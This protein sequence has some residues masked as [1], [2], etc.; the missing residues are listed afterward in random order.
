MDEVFHVPQAQRYCN[1]RFSEWDPKITTFPGLYCLSAL[2]SGLA[3]YV[4]GFASACSPM[5]LRAVNA[6]LGAGALIVM[7]AL[8]RRRMTSDKAAAQAFVLSLYPVHFFFT[9]LYYTDVGSLFWVLLTHHLAAPTPGQALPGFWRIFAA[10]CS[11]FVSVAFRQ[12]NAVWLMFTFGTAALADLQASKRWGD[13]LEGSRLTPKM[14]WTFV[15]ALAFDSGRLLSRLGLLLMPV[16]LFVAFVIWNGSVVVGDHSH[17]KPVLHWAQLGYLVAVTASLWGVVGPDAAVSFASVKAFV[18]LFT[19]WRTGLAMVTTVVGTAC[20]LHR[21]SFAHPF[22]VADNRHYTFYI[23]GRL[24]G[25]IP[26]LKEAL[27]PAYAF[28]A[29]LC[30]QRITRAQSVLWF[31]IW[32]VAVILTVV[33]AHLLE[34]RYWTTAVLLVHLHTP[35]RS[36]AS[37]VTSALACLAVNCITLAIFVGRAFT[38]PDGSIARFMW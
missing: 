1:G 32:C 8:L 17:H 14:L 26:G 2:L 31:L 24:L 10:T 36:W 21:Y 18:T 4:F 38:W 35:E 34:P 6:A 9:F 7:Y 19:R 28:A 20:V 5:G 3:P 12:T 27:A 37:L 33:P 16:L 25:K 29:W 13:D 15:K 23:W 22:L 11:G 30:H